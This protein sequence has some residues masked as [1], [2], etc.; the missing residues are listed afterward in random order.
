M[1]ADGIDSNFNQIL[2]IELPIAQREFL[3]FIKSRKRVET[4]TWSECSPA[5]RQ[6]KIDGRTAIDV[7]DMQTCRVLWLELLPGNQKGC[8]ALGGWVG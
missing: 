1:I 2:D 6:R 5:S 8:S 4:E 7:G 3:V